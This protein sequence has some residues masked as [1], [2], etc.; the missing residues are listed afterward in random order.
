MSFEEGLVVIIY[1]SEG[2]GFDC[3]LTIA[4]AGS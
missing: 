4:Q 1:V 2:E 3:K